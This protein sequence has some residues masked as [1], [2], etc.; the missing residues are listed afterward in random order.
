MFCRA[1]CCARVTAVLHGQKF[2]RIRCVAGSCSVFPGT[3]ECHS[4][5]ALEPPNNQQDL[6]SSI[7]LL[8][9]GLVSIGLWVKLGTTEC[10]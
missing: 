5:R 6:L 9:F 10:D 8:K 1:R 3:A 2:D 7:L 4:R